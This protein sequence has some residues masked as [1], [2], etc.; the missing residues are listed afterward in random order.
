MPCCFA[1]LTYAQC[2]H[3]NLYKIGCTAD[4]DDFCP[5][6]K[7]K[8]LLRTRY[9]WSCE[10]CHNRIN[11]EIDEER[12]DAWSVQIMRACQQPEPRALIETRIEM[13]R[14]RETV[15][16]RRRDR[17]LT[18]QVEEI[19]WVGEWTLEYG[20]VIFKS[21]YGSAWDKQKLKER[22]EQLR[23]L[24]FWDFIITSDALRGSK[25]LIKEQS[26]D[27]FWAVH[28]SIMLE[29]MKRGGL[30]R[31]TRRLPPPPLFEDAEEATTPA[32]EWKDV[33][34]IGTEEE[35]EAM[36]EL[37]KMKMD[38]TIPRSMVHKSLQTDL[39]TAS[40]GDVGGGG[41]EGIVERQRN[42]IDDIE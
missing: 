4:C 23:D 5:L 20:L 32:D 39:V 40:N 33:L 38:K 13:M 3:H 42:T 17:A 16:E 2:R 24:R 10:Q 1:I 19:Q 6:E 25:E 28:N 35:L 21:V 30:R 7:R 14:R 29:H 22:I 26:D 31:P 41:K 11:D 9:L 18:S 8:V 15:K 36:A 12:Q 37:D 27:A 34:E